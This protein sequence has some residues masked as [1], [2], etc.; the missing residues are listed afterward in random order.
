M[1]T[2]DWLWTLSNFTWLSCLWKLFKSS[3]TLLFVPPQYYLQ[4]EFTLFSELLSSSRLHAGS[5]PSMLLVSSVNLSFLCSK[6]FKGSVRL[7]KGAR[8]WHGAEE[9][10]PSGPSFPAT[11]PVIPCSCYAPGE[12]TVPLSGK[13]RK[14]V[15]AMVSLVLLLP[16]SWWPFF[17]S[18]CLDTHWSVSH[19]NPLFLYYSIWHNMYI[20]Y[21]FLSASNIRALQKCT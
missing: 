10:P 14:H 21:D 1:E 5:L 6:S 4:E 11:S 2:T 18:P 16:L 12:G 8:H 20:I 7:A 15:H 13:S 19:A 17:L 3:S 9:S